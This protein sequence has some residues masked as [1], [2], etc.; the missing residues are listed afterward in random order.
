MKIFHR[1]LILGAVM[2]WQINPVHSRDQLG[3]QFIPTYRTQR[4][5]ETLLC[6]FTNPDKTHRFLAQ[7]GLVAFPDV[8]VC[9][10]GRYD[11]DYSA[12]NE[13]GFE[14]EEGE[15]PNP[16]RQVEV[17]FLAVPKEVHVAD[18]NRG[19][20]FHYKGFYNDESTLLFKQEVFH[21]NGEV[22]RI[23][24]R[25]RVTPDTLGQAAIQEMTVK[26][27]KGNVLLSASAFNVSGTA[28][29]IPGREQHLFD[30]ID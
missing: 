4:A 21:Y 22:A 16:L 14:Y 17:I 29:S 20:T 23:N 2:A 8:F 19:G 13:K 18:E 27:P 28:F 5:V 12:R 25:T 3:D 15:L 26:G 30:E 6:G 24:L 11:T 9:L 1:L 7:H 10:S